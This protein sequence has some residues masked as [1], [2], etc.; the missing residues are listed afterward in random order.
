MMVYGSLHRWDVAVW[1]YL[2]ALH[3]LDFS[4][5]AAAEMQVRR[6]ACKGTSARYCFF[7]ISGC[8]SGL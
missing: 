3:Q 1:M 7:K 2:G 5:R 8:L 6:V 4:P